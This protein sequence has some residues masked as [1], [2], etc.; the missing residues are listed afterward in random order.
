MCLGTDTSQEVIRQVVRGERPWTDL[1]TAGIDIQLDGA[2]CHMGNPNDVAADGDVYD[3]AR[4]LL[5]NLPDPAALRTWAFVLQA[6]SFLNWGDAEHH[7]AWETLWD[8]VWRASFGDQVPATAIQTA[9]ELLQ[10]KP[11]NP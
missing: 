10:R 5:A 1:R 8:A 4:G 9:E 6:E 7:P 2:H 11:S 3:L